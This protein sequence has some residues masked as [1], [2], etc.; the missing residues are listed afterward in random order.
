MRT[1]GECIL[2]T[3]AASLLLLGM[4]QNPIEAQEVDREAKIDQAME[5]AP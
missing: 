1:L 4:T 2:E 3:A 5:A